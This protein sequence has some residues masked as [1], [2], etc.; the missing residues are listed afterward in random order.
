MSHEWEASGFFFIGIDDG[1][2]DVTQFLPLLINSINSLIAVG[3]SLLSNMLCVAYN[4]PDIDIQSL[5]AFKPNYLAY[6]VVSSD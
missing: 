5:A 6:K 1:I 2:D 3:M 4:R